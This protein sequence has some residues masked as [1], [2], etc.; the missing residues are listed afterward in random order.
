MRFAVAIGQGLRA[1]RRRPKLFYWGV[2]IL[3]P[4]LGVH[5]AVFSVL[6]GLMFRPLPFRDARRLVFLQERNRLSGISYGTLSYLDWESSGR[7]P[8]FEGI[9]A[10]GRPN[11]SKLTV[12]TDDARRVMGAPVDRNFFSVLGVQPAVG[13]TFVDADYRLPEERVIISHRL[14]L[15]GFHGRSDIVGSLLRY[16]EGSAEI[17][18]VLPANFVFPVFGRAG[19]PDLFTPLVMNSTAAASARTRVM[20]IAR[21]KPRWSIR[22]AQKELDP[23]TASV[24]RAHPELL[25]GTDIR[26]ADPV[27]ALFELYR[28]MLWA[29]LLGSSLVVLA[30]AASMSTLLLGDSIT[31]QV[32]FGIRA[33]LGAGRSALLVQ[34]F[35]EALAV[36]LLVGALAFLAARA[37][38]ALVLSAMPGNIYAIMSA[39]VNIRG[40]FVVLGT[41]GVVALVATVT[42]LVWTSR[43]D[44]VGHVCS[45]RALGARQAHVVSRSLLVIQIGIAV[46]TIA[47]AYSLIG[48]LTTRRTE[49]LG[50]VGA[51]R[52]LTVE[53]TPSRRTYAEPVARLEL[54]ADALERIRHTPG[55]IA[56]GAST[57]VP[58]LE[59]A[60][61]FAVKTESGADA[62]GVFRVTRGYFSAIGARFEDGRDFLPEEDSG[63]AADRRVAIINRQFATQW[64]DISVGK[65]VP[66]GGSHGSVT[67]VGVVQNTRQG[68]DVGPAASL[69][70]PPAAD[71]FKGMVLIAKADEA[72]HMSR[73]VGA[74]QLRLADVDRNMGIVVRPFNTLTD[75]ALAYPRF[76]S[77]L[78]TT[79]ACLSL[80]IAIAGV[81]GVATRNISTRIRELAIRTAIGASR[82]DVVS[83][84]LRQYAVPVAV[85]VATGGW[86]YL[87]GTFFLRSLVHGLERPPLMPLAAASLI[88]AIAAF[89]SVLAATRV[90]RTAEMTQLL[91]HD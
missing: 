88:V 6:D 34:L 77:L 7:H 17:I 61:E 53:I 85:G 2:A 24:R 27:I 9:T 3:G 75:R 67:V 74:I 22:S 89:S 49:T 65:Q 35:T 12:N 5:V 29:F 80:V 23:I 13:R 32:E 83:M 87:E 40:F 82:S 63:D 47:A 86:G 59:A 79:M 19:Q 45:R 11:S 60:A 66:L 1:V 18:G 41:S 64:P 91:R 25:S 42:P 38:F 44:F 52:I 26:L 30:A 51:N 48:D 10:F 81:Y 56:A 15:Q 70:L 73:I 84:L 37:S 62:V 28:P 55:V 90:L 72:E 71:G 20:G 68:F 8:G 54:Y 43:T 46:I 4:C 14:W 31:R 76:Q 39:G 57:N 21:L 78:F 16:E 36:V 33:A 69:Y 50:V 58:L